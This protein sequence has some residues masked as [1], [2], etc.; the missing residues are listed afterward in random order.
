MLELERLSDYLQ[1]KFQVDLWLYQSFLLVKL[2]VKCALLT[3]EMR[4]DLIR[5]SYICRLFFT[6]AEHMDRV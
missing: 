4:S 2:K 1:S 6:S 3:P 5:Q